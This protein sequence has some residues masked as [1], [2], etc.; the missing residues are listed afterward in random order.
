MNSHNLISTLR[1]LLEERKKATE[2]QSV[3]TVGLGWVSNLCLPVQEARILASKI[4]YSSNCVWE[5]SSVLVWFDYGQELV[6]CRLVISHKSWNALQFLNEASRVHA[7]SCDLV[8]LVG[9]WLHQNA[10]S[11]NQCEL[12]PFCT[13]IQLAWPRVMWGQTY[14]S[15]SIQIQVTFMIYIC[16]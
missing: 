8:T 12:L 9:K 14:K 2:I 5:L 11:A 7:G 6:P 4:L 1:N 16:N 3:R 13:I 15:G 10:G